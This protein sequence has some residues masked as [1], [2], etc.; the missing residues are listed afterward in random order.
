MAVT[1]ASYVPL[2][3]REFTISGS[4]SEKVFRLNVPNEHMSGSSAWDVLQFRVT[5][6]NANNLTFV[7]EI[8]PRQGQPEEWQYHTEFIYG[9]SND[10]LTRD[11]HELT[12]RVVDDNDLKFRITN[13][14]GSVTISD[15]ILWYRVSIPS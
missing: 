13:G 1:V 8:Q 10:N 15:I 12:Q 9:P 5:T 14:S 7:A 2:L 11:F 4:G 3:D 6:K